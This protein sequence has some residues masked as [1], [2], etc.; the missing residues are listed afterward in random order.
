MKILFFAV[1]FKKSIYDDGLMAKELE[2]YYLQLNSFF[3]L[4]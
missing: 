2:P 1:I 4:G 3:G